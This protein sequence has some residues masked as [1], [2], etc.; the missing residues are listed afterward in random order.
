M[1]LPGLIDVVA[2]I[3]SRVVLLCLGFYRVALSPLKAALFGQPACC[4][5]YPTCSQYAVDA[6]AKRGLISG[7][8]LV[9]KRIG[10]CHPFHPGGFDPVPLAN[11]GA[12][13]GE[14]H[15]HFQPGNRP[16]AAHFEK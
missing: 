7:G 13:K 1:T 4:R 10:K 12:A 2:G 6:I 14:V 11:G 8:W 5:F 16:S 9:L 3:P 15:Q